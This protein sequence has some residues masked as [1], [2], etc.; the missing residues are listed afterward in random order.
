MN[1]QYM[2]MILIL[3]II[4][5][6]SLRICMN[7][8]LSKLIVGGITTIFAGSDSLG[9]SIDA[10]KK[11]SYIK[12]YLTKNEV[13][14]GI[15]QDFVNGYLFSGKIDTE[16]YSESCVFTDPT[17]SF[18]GLTRFENNIKAIKPL[19]DRFLD[20]TLVILYDINESNENGTSIK[21][22]WRMSGGLRLPWKPRIEL[23]GKI[24]FIVI[25][26]LKMLDIFVYQYQ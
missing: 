9:N 5:S 6:K 19:I 16:I 24:I 25:I 23:T 12:E 10:S 18:K 2:F 1:I 3:M 22:R 13:K 11:R 7:M 21:A 20:D 26:I 4:S 17:L 15:R 8:D 14:E